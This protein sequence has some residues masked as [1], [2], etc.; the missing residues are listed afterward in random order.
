MSSGVQPGEEMLGGVRARAFLGCQGAAQVVRK[1]QLP[2][3]CTVSDVPRGVHA[4]QVAPS[5]ACTR[6]GK[7]GIIPAPGQSWRWTSD[8][9]ASGV[10]RRFAFE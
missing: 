6:G 9:P 10:V 7:G 8:M 4:H 2:R 1:A 5:E 3:S